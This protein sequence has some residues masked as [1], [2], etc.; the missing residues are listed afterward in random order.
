MTYR[1]GERANLKFRFLLFQHPTRP[2]RRH[3]WFRCWW[4]RQRRSPHPT[5]PFRGNTACNGAGKTKRKRLVWSGTQ[6]LS[7][8][9][10]RPGWSRERN[11]ACVRRSSENWLTT[12]GWISKVANFWF[13]R[14]RVCIGKK[15]VRSRQ[16]RID[17]FLFPTRQFSLAK[18]IRF[19]NWDEHVHKCDF[20][21]CKFCFYIVRM[22]V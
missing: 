2:V 3:L 8:R 12:S 5:W 1:Y 6:K 10:E 19:S 22:D 13:L 18:M 17:L 20:F 9:K 11:W 15:C 16:M 14:E 4:F 21:S 7:R